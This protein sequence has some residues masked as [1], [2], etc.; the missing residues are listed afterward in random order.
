MLIIKMA[1]F[2]LVISIIVPANNE[3]EGIHRMLDSPIEC[4]YPSKEIIVVDD[5]SS[6]LTYALASKYV[7]NTKNC[8][9]TIPMSA[10][11]E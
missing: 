7:V 2:I 9:I 5:G 11:S 10:A 6:D 3:Q 1:T 4:D 8:K